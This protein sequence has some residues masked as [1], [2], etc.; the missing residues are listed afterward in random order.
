LTNLVLKLQLEFDFL[1]SYYATERVAKSLACYHQLPE[2]QKS[3]LND[4]E[5]KI[6]QILKCIDHNQEV[7]NS[8]LEDVDDM[9]ETGTINSVNIFI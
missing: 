4:F 1:F 3:Y 7:I 6:K 8:I 2:K 5:D 9:F